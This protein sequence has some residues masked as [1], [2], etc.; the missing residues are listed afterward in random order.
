MNHSRSFTRRS[1][2]SFL[3]DHRGFSE[4]RPS[5]PGLVLLLI[6]HSA[7]V[8]DVRDHEYHAWVKLLCGITIAVYDRGTILIQ[9]T[10]K[11][12]DGP[13]VSSLVREI[14]PAP[15]TVWQVREPHLS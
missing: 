14:C 15:S 13:R 9:G 12:P 10:A 1:F 4:K 6:Q 5:V 7:G 2:D 8:I 3:R 11:Y